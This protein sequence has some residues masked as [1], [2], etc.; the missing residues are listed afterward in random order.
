LAS[1]TQ[2]LLGKTHVVYPVVESFQGK[3][4]ISTPTETDMTI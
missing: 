2:Y 3:S 1:V 4:S